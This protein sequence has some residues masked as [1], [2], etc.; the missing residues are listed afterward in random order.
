MSNDF[1]RHPTGYNIPNIVAGSVTLV[2][3]D[4]VLIT[5]PTGPAEFLA[6]HFMTTNGNS[7]DIHNAT[8]T[9][10][11]DGVTLYNNSF[12]YLIGDLMPYTFKHLFWTANDQAANYKSL[13]LRLKI[14]YESSWSFRLLNTGSVG[15][16]ALVVNAF[17]RY[18]G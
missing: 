15:N 16:L 9:L 14:P 13:G 3:G 12:F 2:P 4:S 11:V 7:W 6:M 10:I 1:E 5:G 17:F 18:G 8:V